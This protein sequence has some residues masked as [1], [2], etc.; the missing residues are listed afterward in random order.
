M[1]FIVFYTEPLRLKKPKLPS[2]LMTNTFNGKKTTTSFTQSAGCLKHI[3]RGHF[4]RE[5]LTVLKMYRPVYIK[6]AYNWLH[7]LM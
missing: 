4:M 3:C 6:I 2:K 7:E 1:I 5:Q